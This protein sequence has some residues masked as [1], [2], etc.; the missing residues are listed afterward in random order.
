M[1]PPRFD[2]TSDG[3]IAATD[4]DFVAW[5]EYQAVQEA[6]K[7]VSEA[8]AS[9]PTALYEC[10]NVMAIGDGCT[11]RSRDTWLLNDCIQKHM[12]NAL[13]KI[14]ELTKP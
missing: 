7:A 6:L 5:E 1:T 3:M 13:A 12:K 11:T 10:D 2:C 14:Q 8:L 4:G 9:L